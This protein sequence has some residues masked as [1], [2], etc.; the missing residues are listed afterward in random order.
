MPYVIRFKDLV[1]PSGRF[2]PCPNCGQSK[3]KQERFGWDGYIAAN[4]RCEGCM[5]EFVPQRSRW[6][7]RKTFLMLSLEEARKGIDEL[8]L[9]RHKEA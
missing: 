4:P 3:V 9:K 1:G 7:R 2:K 5:Y 8:L 6:L